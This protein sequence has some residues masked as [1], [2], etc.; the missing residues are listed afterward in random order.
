M[1]KMSLMAPA[2]S[3]ETTKNVISAGADEI[4]IGLETPGFAN[5]NLS[6]RGR[7][8]NVTT[9]DQLHDIVEYS[10]SHGVQVDYTVNTPYLG[11]G[12]EE[13]FIEHVMRG[14]NA[15]VDALIVG[16]FGA[17]QLIN[18]LD[19]GL[20]IHGSVLLNTFNL[21]QLE[22]LKDMGVTKVVLPFKVTLDEI[23]QLNKTGVELELFGQFGCSNINGTC[24]LIH[25]ADESINFGLPCRANYK[26][27]VDNRLHPILDAGMDCSLCSIPD[28]MDAGVAAL[29]VVGRCMNPE[30]IK[31]IIG[32]YRNAIDM[33]EKGTNAGEIKSHVLDEIPFWE[34]MCEQ[35]RCKY[36]KTPI[37]DSYI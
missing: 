25:S 15:G 13:M 1:T 9:Q 6:G 21:G 35:Q 22:L 10:H 5:L 11:D 29:K 7:S 34:M 32:L 20:Q 8:C 30:M 24:H 12:L 27:S 16:E 19:I 37:A 4:Y 33:S 2:E 23:R 31:T 26:V 28:L 36:M 3:M 14:V 17:L 18:E